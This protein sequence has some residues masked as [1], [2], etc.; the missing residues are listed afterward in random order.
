[1][2]LYHKIILLLFIQMVALA[3]FGVYQIQTLYFSSKNAFDK[4]IEIEALMITRRVEN[5]IDTLDKTVDVLKNSQEIYTGMMSNDADLLYRWAKLF[6][7]KYG[8]KIHFIDEKG[9]VI[10]RG[11]KEF[12]FGDTLLGASYVQKALEKGLFVGMALMDNEESLVV[13]KRINKEHSTGVI[14][15]G[16][17]IDPSFLGSMTLGSHMKMI[18]N[19]SLV[20]K[21]LHVNTHNSV[22]YLPLDIAI[23]TKENKMP[24][25]YLARSS[26]EELDAILA[27]RTNLII[28][29]GLLFGLFFILTYR[30]ILG[31]IR[32]Y[33]RLMSLLFD[34]YTNT[35]SMNH[36]VVL[37]Q[38]IT[39]EAKKFTE[40]KSI[41]DLFYKIVQNM[42]ETQD[43]LSLLSETDGLTQIANRRKL[44]DTLRQKIK[45]GKRGFIFSVVMID[46]DH[47]KQINDTYGHDFGDK[48]LKEIAKILTTHVR[49]ADVL[50]RWGGEEFLLIL[51]STDN[52]GAFQL[53]QTLKERIEQRNFHKD[54]NITASFGIATFVHT[55]S[56]RSLIKRSDDALYRA[57]NLGRNRIE[58]E[59]IM[60]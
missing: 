30:I 16:V 28:G 47:F 42:K 54:M 60:L 55:D 15:M 10:A 5:V 37:A 52:E 4:R 22:K 24:A 34:F 59:T 25:F 17:V 33:D 8:D 19:D 14:A 46:I 32:Y 21:A 38:K 9:M 26:N 36:F 23:E 3:L 48:V 56:E 13:A 44:D 20:S 50:G 29:F 6:I 7:P 27:M 18:Y 39:E 35:I 45:E 40:I 49:E 31:Y 41:A 1:M 12:G 53:A 57:K 58:N 51:P 43:R 2:K 11:E